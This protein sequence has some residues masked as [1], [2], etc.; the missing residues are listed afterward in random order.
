VLESVEPSET[1]TNRLRPVK[2]LPVSIC[3]GPDKFTVAGPCLDAP[4]SLLTTTKSLDALPSAGSPILKVLFAVLIN[5]VV[6]LP[7]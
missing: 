5:G 6:L 2:V 4:L 1:P 7:V 3:S